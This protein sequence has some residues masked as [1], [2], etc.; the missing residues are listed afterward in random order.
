[1]R[2]LSPAMFASLVFIA[3]LSPAII[4][5]RVGSAIGSSDARIVYTSTE[6]LINLVWIVGVALVVG[7]V[8]IYVARRFDFAKG[9]DAKVEDL[10]RLS[11][12]DGRITR[13]QEQVTIAPLQFKLLDYLAS[14]DGSL[15]STEDIFQELYG[16]S[17]DRQ[18]L[19]QLISRLR[20]ELNIHDYI[21]RNEN[22]LGYSFNQWAPPGSDDSAAI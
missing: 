22:N 15:C 13:G 11:I 9:S 6:A 16:N 4:F 7:A 19:N 8:A 2:S 12:S 20:S 5:L 10:Y 18:A 17:D 21:R 14:R 3:A 1:M